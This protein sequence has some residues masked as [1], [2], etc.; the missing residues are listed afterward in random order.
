MSNK[1]I[2]NLITSDGE[3]ITVELLCAFEIEEY[4]SKYIIYT[5]NEHDE[6]GHTIIY[7]G[8]LKDKGGI[9]HLVNIETDEEWI[10]IKEAIKNIAKYGKVGEF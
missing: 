9:E 7:A 10:K 8:G 6:E 1:K 5:K 3:N 4:N 2:I